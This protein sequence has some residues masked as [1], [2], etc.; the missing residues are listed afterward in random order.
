MTDRGRALRAWL[1]AMTVLEATLRADQGRAR[2]AM[3]R[4][5]ATEYTKHG[6]PP[7]HV[8]VA[9]RTRVKGLIED[10]YRRTIPVFAGMALK[11]IKSRRVERKATQTIYESLVADWI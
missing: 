5:A 8:F 1:H 3:I 7:A 6:H 4:K 11:Q 9:H 10:H 2:N